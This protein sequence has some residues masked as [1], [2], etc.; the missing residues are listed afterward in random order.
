VDKHADARTYGLVGPDGKPKPARATYAL[1]A[2]ALK[3]ARFE[4]L[5]GKDETG[6]DKIEAY[7]FSASAGPGKTLLIAWRKDEGAALALPIPAASAVVVDVQGES[8]TIT[9]GQAGD[10]NNSAG[11]LSVG[12]GPSPLLIYYGGP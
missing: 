3:T 4:A 5:L 2:N 9:E 1:L 8:T 12:V 7:R 11:A 10:L 6:S